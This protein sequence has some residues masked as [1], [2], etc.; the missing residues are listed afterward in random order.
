MTSHDY[1]PLIEGINWIQVVAPLDEP[2]TNAL[3]E[4]DFHSDSISNSQD[5]AFLFAKRA[6]SD[7]VVVTKK[8]AIAEHYRPSKFAP[9]YVLDR[10]SETRFESVGATNER[11]ELTSVTSLDEAI[12]LAGGAKAKLLLESGRTFA[13]YLGQQHAVSQLLV[14]VTT[15]SEA[16]ARRTVEHL[17]KDM[18]IDH[19]SIATIVRFETICTAVV[20]PDK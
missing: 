6:E 11:H 5:R 18:K 4:R 20:R 14:T 13:S 16:T 7:A 10:D 1:P 8:T 19:Y 2:D 17:L 15:P 9:I 3:E 12:L